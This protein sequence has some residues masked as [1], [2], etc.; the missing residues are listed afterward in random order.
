MNLLVDS[1]SERVE[2]KKIFE[3]Q[4]IVYNLDRTTYLGIY[5]LSR[6]LLFYKDFA[7]VLCLCIMLH[8]I[9]IKAELLHV[10]IFFFIHLF[11]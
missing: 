10:G 4:L 7:S 6:P 8:N 1:L 3:L 2:K 11:A 5:F 9:S